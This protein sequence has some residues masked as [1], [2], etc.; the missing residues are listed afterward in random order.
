M[1]Y[2]FPTTGYGDTLQ[3]TEEA[4]PAIRNIAKGLGQTY[5]GELGAGIPNLPGLEATNSQN[6]QQLLS[7]AVPTDASQRSAEGAVAA[8][9]P[10]SGAANQR[11]MRLNYQDILSQ[12]QLGSNLLTSAVGRQPNTDVSKFLLSPEQQLQQ[13]LADFTR[14]SAANSDI[15]N[16]ALANRENALNQP[17]QFRGE[18]RPPMVSQPGANNAPLA[19]AH[20]SAPSGNP[21]SNYFNDIFSSNGGIGSAG[22]PGSGYSYN[23]FTSGG[24]ASE[25]PPGYLYPSSGGSGGDSYPEYPSYSHFPD[26]TSYPSYSDYSEPYVP[27]PSP[28]EYDWSRLGAA[29]N[30]VYTYAP[31][32][33]YDPFGSYEDYFTE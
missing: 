24:G 7:G 21:L 6:I 27:T 16:T 12:M 22:T 32:G 4:L 1:A 30:D 15:R 11:G 20:G 5:R 13:Q 10:G 17:S 26:Y 9:I 23:P 19:P 14:R 31:P 8:G 25:R 29:P 33:E 2:A 18:N 3:Q 28:A